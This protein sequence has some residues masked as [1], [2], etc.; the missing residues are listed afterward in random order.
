VGRHHGVF[1]VEGDNVYYTDKDSKGGSRVNGRPVGPGERVLLNN[2]AV[3]GLGTGRTLFVLRLPNAP[4][5]P[6]IETVVN[7]DRIENLEAVTQPVP[8][9]DRPERP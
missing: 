7:M 4:S 5:G 8:S 9:P 1:E 6:S 2:G 3:I